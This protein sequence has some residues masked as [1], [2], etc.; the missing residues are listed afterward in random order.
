MSVTPNIRKDGLILD[1]VRNFVPTFS[2]RVASIEKV[3]GPPVASMIITNYQ[4]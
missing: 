3:E 1:E 4:K 2:L